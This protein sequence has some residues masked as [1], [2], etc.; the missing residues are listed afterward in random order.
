MEN[1]FDKVNE[2]I[3][4]KIRK[5]LNEHGGDIELLSVENGEVRV[6]FLGAC[7][8]CPG[9]QMTIEDIVEIAIMEE[10]PQ[11]QKVTLVSG[12]SEDMLDFAK[13]IL[14]K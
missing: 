8:S 13:K 2:I 12:V 10:L 4:R 7:S 11:I 14:S 5:N 9:A 3:E 1:I 6:R